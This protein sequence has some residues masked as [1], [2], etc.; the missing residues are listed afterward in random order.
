MEHAFYWRKTGNEPEQKMEAVPSD[1]DTCYEE[2][3]VRSSK[4]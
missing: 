4:G 1:S 2:N 3:T